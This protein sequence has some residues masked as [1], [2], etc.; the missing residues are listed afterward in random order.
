MSGR[1]GAFGLQGGGLVSL[2]LRIWLGKESVHAN[3]LMKAGDG[4]CLTSPV[5]GLAKPSGKTMLVSNKSVACLGQS[6][7]EVRFPLWVG[8]LLSGFS[9]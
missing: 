3:S 8:G 5:S 2:G 6:T 9:S 1:P 7:E 4:T